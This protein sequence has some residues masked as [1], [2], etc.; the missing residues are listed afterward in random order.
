MNLVNTFRKWTAYNATVRQLSALDN[1]MLNDLGINRGDIV[2][3]A[4]NH[5]KSL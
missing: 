4:R 5:A 3:V 2:R 1:R